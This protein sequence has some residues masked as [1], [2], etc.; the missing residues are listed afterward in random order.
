M[1]I[2]CEPRSSLGFFNPKA[3]EQR[4]LGDVVKRY[5]DPVCTPSDGYN[6]LGIRSHA[7]GVF[8]S[9]VEKGEELSTG[10][11][12]RVGVGNLIVNITFAWEHAVAIT[13]E[14]DR[15]FLV[16]QRF[17]QFS[18]L[19]GNYPNF[20]KYVISKDSF[21]H[22]LWLSSPGGAGRNRVLNQNEMLEYN[23]LLPSF[24]EQQKMAEVLELCDTLITLHQRK[25]INMKGG[26][27]VM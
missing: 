5:E 22:H 16:S 24:E 1:I 25:Q 3:W 17:P 9:H 11:L 8:H 14:S 13:A 20:F 26:F 10:Q 19:E 12:Y 27:Y 18:F 2:S 15:D 4:K 7:K 6:R 23:V 21:R